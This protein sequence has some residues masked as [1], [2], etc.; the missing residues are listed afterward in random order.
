[1]SKTDTR[2]LYKPPTNPR[3]AIVF[4]MALIVLGL[5]SFSAWSAFAKLSSAVVSSGTL[6]VATNRKIVQAAEGGTIRVI[7]VE[8]GQ[9]V[10]AGDVLLRLD[11]TK[12]RASLDVIQSRYDLEQATV[13][14]L[15]AEI[16]DAEEISFSDDLLFRRADGSVAQILESQQRLFTARRNALDGQVK[17]MREKIRQLTGKID[18]LMSQSKAVNDRAKL[19]RE[20]HEILNQLLDRNLV[21]KSRV[22]ELQ[23]AMAALEGEKGDLEAQIAAAEAEIAQTNLQV[24]Q[25]TMDF[26]EEVNDELG[27]HEAAMYELA[28]QLL[29]ARHSL[30]QL[31]V[32]ATESGTVVDLT[33]HTIGGVVEPSATLLEIVPNKDD[34]I[35]E[36]RIRPEDVD[37][38]FAG[39]ATDIVFSGLSKRE[40]PRLS[41]SVAYVSA[42][43]LTDPRSGAAYFSVHVALPK[44]EI[45]KIGDHDLVPGMPAE[46]YIKTSEQTPFAYLTQPLRQSLR[47]AW[48]ES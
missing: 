19:S 39:L 14:R 26:E 32:R 25:V 27:K 13:A 46:V 30:E 21:S 2:L 41:G 6:K 22:L 23:R 11:D 28:Q 24:L 44:D 4:G 10:T 17:V 8:N 35:I 31:V 5:G 34:L 7:L 45:A 42:D 47:H 15:R 33:V 37:Q 3:P 36:T 38:V 18:G 48:R 43:A 12:A 16:E 29:D 1:M 40:T 9:K 20:E